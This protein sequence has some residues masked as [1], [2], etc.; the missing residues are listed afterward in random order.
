MPDMRLASLDRE[1]ARKG[2]PIVLRRYTGPAGA[3]LSKWSETP[4][5][6]KVTPATPQEIVQGIS[7]ESARII[8]SPTDVGGGPV[9]TARDAIMIGMAKM[10][11]TAWSPIVMGGEVVRI[12]A[13]IG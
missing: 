4:I 11:I 6:A 3:P 7:A 1:L 8:A 9:V 12:E 2:Q 13:R 10:V 5:R